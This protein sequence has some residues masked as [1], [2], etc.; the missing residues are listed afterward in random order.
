MGFFELV[1]DK[2]NCYALSSAAVFSFILALCYNLPERRFN[3][4]VYLVKDLA[5]MI[6][7]LQADKVEKVT[8]SELEAD[9]D[10]PASLSFSFVDNIGMN[11]EYD[12]IESID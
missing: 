3:M 2:K 7:Q 12:P 6:S 8:I 5:D 10:F 11:V 4:A 1:G 9:E